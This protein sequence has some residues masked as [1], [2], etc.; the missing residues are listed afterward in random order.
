MDWN[1]IGVGSVLRRKKLN[2]ESTG[3]FKMNDPIFSGV[4][5]SRHFWEIYAVL[6]HTCYMS[7]CQPVIERC[8]VSFFRQI[9]VLTYI[10]M[11]GYFGLKQPKLP[12]E[13]T[14][15]RNLRERVDRGS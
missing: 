5:S 14:K 15:T 8:F 1:V 13:N 11:F 4:G 10:Y 2:D 6:L 7:Q 12:G 3:W 9:F